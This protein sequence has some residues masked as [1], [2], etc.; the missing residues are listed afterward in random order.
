MNP[1]IPDTA[2]SAGSS[3]GK[4]LFSSLGHS[5]VSK[6]RWYVGRRPNVSDCGDLETS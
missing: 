1:Y 5:L 4:F 2:F 3:A 6:G